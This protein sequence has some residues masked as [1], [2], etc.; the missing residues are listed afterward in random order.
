[1]AKNAKEF[2]EEIGKNPELRH[3]LFHQSADIIFKLAKQHG[4]EFTKQELNDA[5]RAKVGGNAIPESSKVDD[6]ANCMVVI[7]A[8][9]AK[10]K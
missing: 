9:S 8:A 10:T 2:I 7:V 1:M 6:V 3:K 4:Y 5:L